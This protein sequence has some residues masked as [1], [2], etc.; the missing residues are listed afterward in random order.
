MKTSQSA[1][2]RVPGPTVPG[3]HAA[4]DNDASTRQRVA[5]SI[6]QHGP[7]TA[8]ELA[9]RLGLTAAG[10]R[11][12]L[13]V[14]GARGAVQAREQ[15]VYGS[16]GRGRPAKVFLLTDSGRAEFYSSYDDLAIKAL[17]FLSEAV[18]PDAVV[19][20]AESRVADAETRYREMMDQADPA[21]SPAQ[22]L[23]AA[24][25]GDGYVA[26]TRPS[27]V[28]EQLCQHH[29]PVAHVAEKFPQ[30]CEAETDVFSRLLGVHVQRL[31]TIAHGD[32]VCTTHIP[33]TA[34]PPSS[35][36]APSPPLSST[37][38]PNANTETPPPGK[39]N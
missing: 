21:L 12:H 7:S 26:S 17:A 36:A 24:L 13:D 18:G 14:L 37:A 32:G 23:A 2:S 30:L 15:R 27:A 29:C 25:S 35:T 9:E 33:H 20:F 11:R 10:I 8:A 19:K 31:A 16:R 22:T 4:T 3:P 28:G 5:N 34:A 39:A 38:A 1:A 6:L